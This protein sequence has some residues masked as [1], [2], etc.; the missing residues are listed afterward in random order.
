MQLFCQYFVFLNQ[1]IWTH[2]TEDTCAIG[3]K[4]DLEHVGN[5]QVLNQGL[6]GWGHNQY[7]QFQFLSSLLNDLYSKKMDVILLI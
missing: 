1:F 2:H 5:I 6:D 7:Q 4:N 3:G